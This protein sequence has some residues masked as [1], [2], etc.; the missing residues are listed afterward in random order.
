MAAQAAGLGRGSQLSTR[1]LWQQSLRLYRLSDIVPFQKQARTDSWVQ[2]QLVCLFQRPAPIPS[3][4]AAVR[5][6]EAHLA[7]AQLCRVR[8]SHSADDHAFAAQMADSPL[9]DDRRSVSPAPAAANGKRSVS[10]SPRDDR[11]PVDRRGSRSPAPRS[12]SPRDKSRSRERERSRASRSPVRERRRRSSTPPRCSMIP[13]SLRCHAGR[14]A[15]PR[16]R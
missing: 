8:K 16:N 6:S 14:A 15:R 11:S 4:K 7:S 1:A 2:D 13:Q 12:P 5:K 9:G 10:R 3:G